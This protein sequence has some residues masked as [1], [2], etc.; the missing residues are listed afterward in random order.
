VLRQKGLVST[1]VNPI[2][3]TPISMLL[4][5]FGLYLQQQRLL[6]LGKGIGGANTTTTR[7]LLRPSDREEESLLSLLLV[8]SCSALKAILRLRR[9]AVKEPVTFKIANAVIIGSLLTVP[10]RSQSQAEFKSFFS[11]FKTAVMSADTYQL[12]DLMA[13]DFDFLGN[14]DASPQDVFKGLG[15]DEW[16]NLQSAVQK[17]DFVT[18]NYKG[19][20]SRLLKCTPGASDHNCYVVFQTDTSGKWRWSALVMPKK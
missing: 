18:Q 8:E 20:P 4:G 16:T 15:S 13:H 11:E 7:H 1:P 10:A 6:A 9:E 3:K 12:Q 14:A 2:H 5:E 17:G 19:K